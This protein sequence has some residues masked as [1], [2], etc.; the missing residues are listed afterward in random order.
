MCSSDLFNFLF[1]YVSLLDVLISSW[2]V[3]S[4]SCGVIRLCDA[5]SFRGAGTAGVQNNWTQGT[6]ETGK[7]GGGSFRW[8][9]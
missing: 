4:A 2:S 6:E 1:L 8:L 3:N 5:L 9:V 7:Q